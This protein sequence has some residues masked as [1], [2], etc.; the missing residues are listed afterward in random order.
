VPCHVDGVPDRRL[1]ARYLNLRKSRTVGAGR[2]APST[3]AVTPATPRCSS[4]RQL[5]WLR[6]MQTPASLRIVSIE[7]V[8]PQMIAYLRGSLG[9]LHDVREEHRGQYAIDVGDRDRRTGE[10]LLHRIEHRA[11]LVNIPP[12]MHFTS[13]FEQ[14][15]IPEPGGHS[16]PA[17]NS[18]DRII[19]AM[20]DERRRGNRWQYRPGIDGQILIA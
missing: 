20:Y 19:S 17:S 2:E 18:H 1:G 12:A 14:L 10:K 9:R 6:S 13:K 4:H 15:C 11:P 7:D 5:L 16:T 8:V 3:T